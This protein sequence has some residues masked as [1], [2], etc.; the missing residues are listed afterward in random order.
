LPGP[1]RG[2]SDGLAAMVLMSSAPVSL[3]CAV[4][5]LDAFSHTRA[6]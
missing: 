5:S 3:V 6:L 2:E 1:S 4:T